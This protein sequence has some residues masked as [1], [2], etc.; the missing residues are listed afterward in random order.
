MDPDD[1]FGCRAIYGANTKHGIMGKN[2]YHV[3]II[4]DE[5]DMTEIVTV[6]A[7]D[8]WKARTAA[9]MHCTMPLAGQFVEYRIEE[10]D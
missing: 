10:A 7:A 1:S 8:E 6:E 9:M 5:L 4:C 2:R 3:T